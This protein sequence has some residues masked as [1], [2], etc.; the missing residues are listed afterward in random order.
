[1]L[2]PA[3]LRAET[4]AVPPGYS[5]AWSDEFNGRALD[6]GKWKTTVNHRRD[7]NNVA[8]AVSVTNGTLR[9]T[10]YSEGGK[11]FTGFVSTDGKYEPRFGYIEARIRFRTSPGMW[12]AFWVHSHSVG[13]PLG[14]PAKA[15]TEI[16]VVE[17]RATD[18]EGRDLSDMYVMN[19][20]WDGY[21]PGNH[22]SDGGKSRPSSDR[23]PLQGEWHNYGLLWT[24]AGYRFFLDGVEQWSST[25]AVSQRAEHI[26][27]TSEIE[28]AGWAG[29]VPPQGYGNRA[30]S[31]TSMEVDWVRVYQQQ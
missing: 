9:I 31:Q 8:E 20:H 17:H 28:K 19:L 3:L 21:K 13:N 29:N 16:D 24:D 27:L 7:A 23:K 6:L 2:S 10:T 12:S 14:D 18:K 26:L 15:G 22:K 1:M 30:A 25:K 5:L 4:N 11:H